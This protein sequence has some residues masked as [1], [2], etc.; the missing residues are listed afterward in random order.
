VPG[1]HE[2]RGL[3]GDRPFAR[4]EPDE[5]AVGDP[6]PG[7]LATLA[8]VDA[9]G[10]G[11]PRIGPGDRV[12]AGR[13]AAPL[14]G[15]AQDREA[16]RADLERRAKGLGLP[17]REPFVVHSGEAVGVD[18]PLE[19]L[20]LVPGVG[21]HEHAARAEH[22]VVVELERERFPEPERVVVE[23]DTLGPQIVGAA[24][25]R[26]AAGVAEPDPP[27]LEHRHAPDPVPAGEVVGGREPVPAAAHDDRV[28]AAGGLRLAPLLG[29]PR[30]PGKALP[31]EIRER[32]PHDAP[33]SFFAGA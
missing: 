26:V 22:H 30:S 1:R 31:Q 27:L 17:R 20:G 2:R 8:D 14:Q 21:E 10:R 25:R 12:V 5:P 24:D 9:L 29:P 13:A 28:V 7:H 4:F 15:R 23:R 11:G 33:V 19:H 18:V 32:K 6:D 16:Q 3:G